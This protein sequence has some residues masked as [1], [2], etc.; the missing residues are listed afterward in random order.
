MLSINRSNVKSWSRRLAQRL[1]SNQVPVVPRQPAEND[2]N[3]S[4]QQTDLSYHNRTSSSSK[5]TEIDPFDTTNNHITPELIQA[6]L[7][8]YESVKRLYM[9]P[10][11]T[12]QDP[13]QEA[14]KSWI[15]A[16]PFS[17]GVFYL[18]KKYLDIERKEF[19]DEKKELQKLIRAEGSDYSLAKGV[20]FTTEEE[21]I[22]LASSNCIR[23]E[24]ED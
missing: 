20:M 2:E 16:I 5:P 23:E 14:F 10:K 7:H 4:N 12:L 18:A 9:I 13:S 11:H 1:Q 6:K 24:P 15:Y 8:A 19:M 3:T 21:K 22:L 17:L